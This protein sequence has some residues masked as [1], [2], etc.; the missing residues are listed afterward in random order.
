MSG[1]TAPKN[2]PD[3]R[4]HQIPERTAEKNWQIGVSDTDI[5]GI[6]WDDE[7]DRSFRREIDALRWVNCR[8]IENETSSVGYPRR[9]YV[10]KRPKNKK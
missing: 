7:E 1:N 2:N 4:G 9:Y 8:N 10:R 3:G 5:D 6:F